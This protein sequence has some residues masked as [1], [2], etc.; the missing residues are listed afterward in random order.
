MEIKDLILIPFYS[1]FILIAG[2]IGGELFYPNQS[3]KKYLV[4]GLA[5]KLLGSVL[6]CLV[7]QFYYHGGDTFGYYHQGLKIS[8]SVWTDP[9]LTW[10]LL[11]SSSRNFNLHTAQYI[12]DMSFMRSDTTFWVVK[13]SAVCN[14]F[15][16]DS[17]Y[18]TAL[19][20]ATFAFSGMWALFRIFIK[21]FPQLEW[22]AALACLAIPSLVFWGSGIMKDTITIG[23]MGWVVYGFYHLIIERKRPISSFL[24]MYVG[25]VL[26]LKI[27][28]YILA[29]LVPSL[30]IWGIGHYSRNALKETK[31]KIFIWTVVICGGGVGLW[32]T[33]G[34]VTGSVITFTELFIEK[35][36]DFQMWHGYVGSAGLDGGGSTYSLGNIDFSLGGILSKVPASINV[37]LFRPYLTEVHSPVVIPAALESLTFLLSS[38]F[39]FFFRGFK[40]L[41]ILWKNP[42]LQGFLLFTLLFAFLVGF[43]SFN[44]GALVRYKIP[45]LPFVSFLLLALIFLGNE[46]KTIV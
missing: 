22:Q 18:G 46:K 44:F 41:S 27:K 28:F 23:A 34:K 31:L 19:L 38:L 25:A 42:A 10:Q 5:L 30:L 8:S 3:F 43:T 12:S 13:I 24:L 36:L 40:T 9:S 17:F 37:A 4:P 35:A 1:L 20:F 16:F 7:Y 39:L 26:L 15:A 21:C 45:C 2:F 6:F 33:R 29:A 32:F 11:T 14:L